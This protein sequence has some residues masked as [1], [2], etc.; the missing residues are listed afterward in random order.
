MPDTALVTI[1]LASAIV[2]GET[3]DVGL[4][5]I[6]NEPFP[7]VGVASVVIDLEPLV[8]ADQTVTVPVPVVDFPVTATLSPLLAFNLLITTTL[9]S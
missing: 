5:V 6:V 3:F 4:D 7:I 1:E 9:E 2:A 8:G